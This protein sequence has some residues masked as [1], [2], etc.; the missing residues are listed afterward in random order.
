MVKPP[1]PM[2]IAAGQY[3]FLLVSAFILPTSY[4]MVF[5]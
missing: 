3:A 4:A 1:D 2:I 5:V